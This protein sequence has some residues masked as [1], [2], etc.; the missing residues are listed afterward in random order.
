MLS[1]GSPCSSLL[2]FCLPTRAGHLH[3]PTDIRIRKLRVEH[4]DHWLVDGGAKQEPTPVLLLSPRHHLL[5]VGVIPPHSDT[6]YPKHYI[7]LEG[8]GTKKNS[9][10]EFETSYSIALNLT[11]VNHCF[12][13]LFFGKPFCILSHDEILFMFLV[14]KYGPHCPLHTDSL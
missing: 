3:Q 1:K 4:I 13:L 2:L 9:V 12:Y 10:V 5:V 14:Q 8:S 7:L 6:K 11:N